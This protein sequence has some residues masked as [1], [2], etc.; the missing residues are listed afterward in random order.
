MME[1]HAGA[2]QGGE[3]A[4]GRSLVFE[5]CV[6]GDFEMQRVRRQ[7]RV[8]EDHQR[9]RSEVRLREQAAG[10]VH[11][12]RQ[13]AQPALDE[14]AHLVAPRVRIDEVRISVIQRQKP[15]LIGREAEEI[16]FLDGPLD[17][18]AMW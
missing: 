2:L 16:G 15:L 9:T 11:A 8:L 6:L 3:F 12:D 13:V 14:V 10:N 1:L 5:Q 4:Q 18:R 17:R 7:L